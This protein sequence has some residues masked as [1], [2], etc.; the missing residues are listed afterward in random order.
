MIGDPSGKSKERNLQTAEG[1]KE[2]T[3][4]IRKQLEKFIDLS[5]SN[6]GE[7][8][9]NFDWL[10]KINLI[11][12]LRDYGK[13][14][15]INYMLSKEIVASRLEAGISFTEFSYQI[16][17]SI[18]FLKL[19]EDKK[20][21]IQLGGGDQWGNLTSGLELIR[22]VKGP[23]T[24]VEVFTANLITRSDGK[25]FGKSEDGALFLN[26]ELTSPYKL[27]QY[28]LN[29]TDNDAI[30]YLKVFTFLSL[31]E[32]NEISKKHYESLGSF[33]AQKILAKE[34]VTTI[35]GESGAAKAIKM[36]EA[37]FSGDIKSLS[38]EELEE[39]LLPLK[40]DVPSNLNVVDLLVAVKA[41][42]SKREAR[43]F[44]TNGAISLNGEKIGNLELIC[45]ALNAL[46][47]KYFVIR[48][49]K[50][51]YFLAKIS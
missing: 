49:G 38:E 22:K 11:D 43:E 19:Y 40:V 37:L 14:F 12:F 15:P 41:A 3:E 44:L 48:R 47:N 18:D 23:D 50:K 25:K 20:C 17:Q 30:H 42:S 7:I 4:C 34:V 35:H 31:D 28:F 21:Q 6:K 32:I 46:F 1:V 36:S 8:V 51:N 2:N 26:P 45:S 9:N 16:L 29:T 5:D 33:Y 27:Y 13:H 24:P 10:S 39:L